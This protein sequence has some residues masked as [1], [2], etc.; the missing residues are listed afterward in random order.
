M[1]PGVREYL[2]RIIN[3]LSVG[4]FWLAINSTAGIMYDHAFF[5]GSITTGN[6]IFYIWFISSFILLLRWLI[7][8]WSKPIDFEQ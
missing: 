8:L 2:L 1:E 4:L 3:T 6:I 5:H 7:K